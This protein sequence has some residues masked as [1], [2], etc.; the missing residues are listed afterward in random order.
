M[1]TSPTLPRRLCARALYAAAALLLS[2]TFARAAAS[3]TLDGA[4]DP[5]SNAWRTAYARSRAACT[6]APATF[7]HV[8]TDILRLPACTAIGNAAA[9]SPPPRA[10]HA[11]A[12][13]GL[14]LTCTRDAACTHRKTLLLASLA[15]SRAHP[16]LSGGTT[17]TPLL[18]PLLPDARAAAATL[19]AHTLRTMRGNII[20]IATLTT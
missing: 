12:H 20:T 16:L 5:G 11:L 1:V 9:A 4:T 17:R 15:H 18:P 7:A 14:R 10:P 8:V 2:S 6:S 3:H 13:T 19:H